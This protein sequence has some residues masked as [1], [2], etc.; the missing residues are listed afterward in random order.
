[1]GMDPEERTTFNTWRQAIAEFTGVGLTDTQRK[2]RAERKAYQKDLADCR[3]CEKWRNE[4]LQASPLVK[5]MAD[6]LQKS[7]FKLD[8]QTMACMKCDEMRS[9]GFST[10]GAIQLCYNK[11]F[12]KGHLETTM[13]HEMVHAYDHTNFNVDWYNLEHHACTEI[14]AASLSGDCTWF[15]ELL[16]GNVGFL[17]HHQVCVKRR[18]VLSLL[19]NPSCRSEKH[20]EAAV[21]KVFDS[22][23]T[24]TRPFDE[25]Y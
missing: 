4:L 3:Q 10:D 18:A 8:N 1:M 9:G 6:N 14:R 23:F 19:A 25:I 24:D 5:F 11:L 2:E 20:A 22:C 17:K 7:G 16:R 12:G 21:N 15:Q 13:T